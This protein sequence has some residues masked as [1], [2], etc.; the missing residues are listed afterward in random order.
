MIVFAAVWMTMNQTSAP[1]RLVVKV[2]AAKTLNRHF[3]QYRIFSFEYPF[4]RANQ[5]DVAEPA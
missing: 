2:N 3:L 1:V 4:R 5:V